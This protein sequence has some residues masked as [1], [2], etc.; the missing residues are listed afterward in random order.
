[1]FF[2]LLSVDEKKA[3]L[4]LFYQ[5][6][7][8]D[9]EFHKTERLLVSGYALEMGIENA[10]PKIEPLEDVLK[11][12]SKSTEYAKKAVFIESIGLVLADNRTHEAEMDILHRIQYAF[13]LSD[14]FKEAAFTWVKNMLPLYVQGF[15]LVGLDVGLKS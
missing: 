5:I 7:T 3:C 6:A 11:L 15:Q 9:Q 14:E 8:C 10:E 4:S 12:F 1:M 2:S 13:G